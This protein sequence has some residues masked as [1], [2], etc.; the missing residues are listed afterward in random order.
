MSLNNA[1]EG[2]QYQDL[3]CAY[4]ILKEVILGHFDAV[5]TFDEKHIKD[6][7]FDDLVIENGN[8]IQRKQIKYSNDINEKV[9]SKDDLSNDSGTSLAIYKLF[10]N[11]QQLRT[12]NTEFRLCLAWNPPIEDNIIN[13]LIRQENYSSF[14]TFE[15]QVFK[16]NLDKVWQVNPENFNRW[17]NLNKYVQCEFFLGI[18]RLK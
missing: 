6:D 10:E 11:W 14:S 16:F 15:T 1:H 18:V 8:S 7:R 3:L 5:L 9:L 17:D 2:Y 4:F 12:D 13:A